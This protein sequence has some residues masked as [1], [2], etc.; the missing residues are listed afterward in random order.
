MRR[1]K[2]I[3]VLLASSFLASL[4]ASTH[5]GHAQANDV[6]IVPWGAPTVESA[7]P[8]A[9]P[10][11]PT[12]APVAKKAEREDAPVAKAAR[13]G[14]RGQVVL[15]A[16][17]GLG[18]G[19]THYSQSEASRFSVDVSPGVDVFFEKYIS[20][21]LDLSADYSQSKGYGA[22]ST[23]VQTTSTTF[24]IGPRIGALVPLG[25]LLSWYPRLTMSF[26][27]STTQQEVVEGRSLSVASFGTPSSGTEHAVRLVVY[28]PLVLQLAQG[29][30]FGLGPRFAQDLSRKNDALTY[31]NLATSF[32]VG[33]MLGG[34]L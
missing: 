30:F 34:W 3:S 15:S 26:A 5:L 8:P 18:V 33:A 22:D 11:A 32:G 1:T 20:I 19:S 24:G 25:D 23:L 2:R 4:L 27:S 31:Q 28:A 10:P 21:G 6:P 29:L 13:F 16:F 7:P 9:A 12:I 14:A 17:S